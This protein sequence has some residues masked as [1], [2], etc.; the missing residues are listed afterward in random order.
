MVKPTDTASG[1]AQSLLTELL[2]YDP[3]TGVFTWKVAR[4]G[5]VAVGGVAGYV[6][7]KDGYRHIWIG[8]RLYSAARLAWLYMTGE[9]P[10]ATVDHKD[11][12]RTNDAWLNLRAATQAQQCANRGMKK[13]NKSGFKGV[14]LVKATGKWCASIKINGKSKNLGSTYSTPEEAAAV[15]AKVLTEAHGEFARAAKGE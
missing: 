2:N 6:S 12:N 10:V 11:L 4:S 7:K 15:Y 3:V 5:N 14:S 1:L 9:W 13:G 8:E